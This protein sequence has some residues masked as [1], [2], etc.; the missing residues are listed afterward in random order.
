MQSHESVDGSRADGSTDTALP[1][2][3]LEERKEEDDDNMCHVL[4]VCL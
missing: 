1:V 3:S 4:F 2:Y